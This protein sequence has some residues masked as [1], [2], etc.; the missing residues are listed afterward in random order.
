MTESTH[1][2]LILFC[3]YT[4]KATKL[5]EL[6][7]KVT[8]NDGFHIDKLASIQYDLVEHIASDPHCVGRGIL[9][10]ILRTITNI[11]T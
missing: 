11:C 3:T 7:S 9:V 5:L 8:N 10:R 2:S 6:T 1:A 4:T